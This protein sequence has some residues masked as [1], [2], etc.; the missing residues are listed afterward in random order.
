MILA[1]NYIFVE[2]DLAFLKAARW[3]SLHTENF[4]LIDPKSAYYRREFIMDLN[5]ASVNQLISDIKN[6]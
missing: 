4:V 1:R 5:S 6:P 2:E 3:N